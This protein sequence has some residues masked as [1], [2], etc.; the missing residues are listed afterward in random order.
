MPRVRDHNQPHSR[1]LVFGVFEAIPRSG[2]LRK[3]GV[4]IPLQRRPFQALLLL[5]EHANEVVTREELQKHLWSPD[6]F[7]DFDHGLNTAIRKIRLALN[8]EAEKPRFIE[9]VGRSGYRFLFPVEI[10]EGTREAAL[11]SGQMSGESQVIN[12]DIASPAVRDAYVKP[13]PAPDETKKTSILRG[14]WSLWVSAGALVAAILLLAYWFRPVMPAPRI[15]QVVQLTNSGGA[16]HEDPLYTDGPRV[17]YQSVGPLSSEFLLRQVLLNS[18]QDTPAGLPANRFRVRGLSPDDTEFLATSNLG[19]STVWRVPVSSGSPRP[20]DSLVAED[21]AYSHDGNSLAYSRGNQLFL[22]KS[23]ATSSRLVATVPDVSSVVEHIRWSPDD[24]LIR[25]TATS[26][27]ATLATPTIQALWEVGADGSNPHEMQF[28]WPGKAVECCGEWTP[29][30]R[31]FVFQSGRQGGTSNLWALEEKSYWWRRPNHDPV[32]LTFGPVNYYQPLPSR[33][34]Q[35]IFAIGVQP[36]GELVRYDAKRQEFVPFLGG[37]SLAHLAFSHDHQWVAYVTFP[38]GTLWR[39]R[40]DGSD[41]LQLT[42]PPLH[43]GSPRWSEDGKRIVFHAIRPGQLWHSFIIPADGGNPEPFAQDSSV[44]IPDWVPGRDALIY[45]HAYGAENPA[46][47]IFDRK[48]G[49]SEKMPG[50]DGLYGPIWSP[51]GHY[52]A[53]VDYTAGDQLMLFD[54]RTGKWTRISG[55]AAWPAWSPDSEYIYFVRWGLDSILRVHVPDG[56]EEKVLSVPFRL[57]LW[58]FTVAPDGSLILLREHGRYDVYAL[59]MS[60]P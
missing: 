19:E 38:E 51:D 2:E 45:S 33:N 54:P 17:Y 41:P 13:A 47:Y 11:T 21:I 25:F 39:A 34:G 20:I 53:A 55:R 23:D 57:T 3:H 42:F 29:D 26:Q 9:T 6:T 52:L 14:R 28:A 32:Q 43:V 58:P 49:Q 40:I 48:S 37:R 1:K 24:Q 27:I 56:K 5:L 15:R 36:D 7:V 8:D 35:S 46:I 60:T 44:S 59:S 10:Q 18:N 12:L 16:R 4:R 50:T 31:Y 22:A 30:G